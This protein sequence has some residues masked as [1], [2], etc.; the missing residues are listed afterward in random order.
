[1][2]KLNLHSAVELVRY[3]AKFGMIDVGLWKK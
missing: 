2:K 3:A 1:M